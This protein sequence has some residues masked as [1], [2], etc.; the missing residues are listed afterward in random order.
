[1]ITS[2]RIARRRKR[3]YSRKDVRNEDNK[4]QYRVSNE[5]EHNSVHEGG[6]LW[7]FWISKQVYSKEVYFNGKEEMAGSF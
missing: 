7:L 5:E 3:I 2:R 6:K 4:E 1:M